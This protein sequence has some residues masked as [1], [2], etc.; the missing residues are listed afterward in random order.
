M[1]LATIFAG[2]LLAAFAATGGAAAQSRAE[3]LAPRAEVDP[4]FAVGLEVHKLAEMLRH[5]AVDARL[6]PNSGL[7]TQ[8]RQL[9]EAAARRR[10]PRPRPELGPAWDLQIQVTDVKPEGAERLA[11]TAR[12]FLATA[13]GESAPVRLFFRRTADGWVLDRHEGLAARIAALTAE[14]GRGGAR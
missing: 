10:R 3:G 13:E 8:A 6:F 5:G 7:E 4:A 12:V 11:A 2:A 14:L 1:K 9:A